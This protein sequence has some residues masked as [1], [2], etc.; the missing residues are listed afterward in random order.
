MKNV[1]IIGGGLAGLTAASI[2]TSK[3]YSVT[4]VEAS[5]KLGGRTYSFIDTDTKSVIDNGQHILMGCYKETLA[6][7]KLIGAEKNFDYQKNLEINF[8]SKD[9]L[10][11]ALKAAKLIY[12][13]N[14]L[15]AIFNYD[16]FELDDKIKFI[17]F[18]IKLPFQSKKSL[19]KLSVKEWLELS[20]Q[21]S[22]T[23]KM[24]WEIL[25]VGAMNTSLEN[26]SAF[27]F[28]KILI[29]MF[30]KGNFASTIILPKYELS[31]SIVSPS[32]NFI[33]QN[34]GRIITSEQVKEV[35]IQNSLIHKVTTSNNT[36]IEFDYVVSAIPLH[37]LG[38][39]ID[40]NEVEIK[41]EFEYS[42]IINILIWCDKFKLDEMFYGLLDSPLH[43]VFRKEDHLNIVI[44]NADYLVEKSTEEIFH[45]VVT[46][47][48]KFFNITLSKIKSYKIIKEKRA[49]FI[50]SNKILSHRPK[51]KT[52]I[53]NL[54]LAGDWIDTDLPATI[55]SAIKSG[56]LAAEEIISLSK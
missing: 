36:Y 17:S 52:K 43:W 5:P 4:V 30:F 7:L 27:Y 24:F 28:Q 55:E 51:S 44:S 22:N 18:V 35:C 21:S 20:G 11:Y 14:L 47:L 16:A 2:L 13:F 39:I 46:E 53:E 32:R 12:P 33:L 40:L 42:T 38:K 34:G 31:K 1:L 6:F 37:S 23:I 15:Y 26:S 25:C 50:P 48:S 10:L 3:K 49:T 19:R 45:F 41:S 8:L 54:L 9:R 29:E 56:R